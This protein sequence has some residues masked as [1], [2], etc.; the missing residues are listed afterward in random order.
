MYEGVC[1][2]SGYCSVCSRLWICNGWKREM[3]WVWDVKINVGSF[4]SILFLFS[5]VQ[6]YGFLYSLFFRVVI[7]L[8]VTIIDNDV[9]RHGLDEYGNWTT[10]FDAK[11]IWLGQCM[12]RWRHIDMPCC[13]IRYVLIYWDI[14][15]HNLGGDRL[16]IGKGWDDMSFTDNIILLLWPCIP[17]FPLVIKFNT[18]NT[19]GEY[20]A[21]Q[22]HGILIFFN[23]VKVSNRNKHKSISIDSNSIRTICG[24]VRDHIIRFFHL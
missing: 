2:C 9:F 17:S 21:M 12:Y 23:F 11:G 6:G 19:G 10:A 15:I 16:T 3:V 24:R 22:M 20:S 8:C 7:L 13:G 18:N 4:G 1:V 5:F 14:G